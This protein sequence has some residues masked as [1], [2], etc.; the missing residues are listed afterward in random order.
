[1]RRVLL[2]VALAG[3]GRVGFSPRP[4][5]SV[6]DGPDGTNDGAG[7]DGAPLAANRVFVT[8]T[9]QTAALGGLAGADAICQGLAN[10]AS[11]SGTYIALLSTTTVDA[12]TRLGSARGWV[13]SDGLPFADTAA[14]LF[15]GHVYFPIRVDELGRDIGTT[16]GLPTYSYTATTVT[17]TYAAGGDCAAFTGTSSATTGGITFAG[18]SGWVSTVMMLCSLQ[19]HL[20][21]FEIDRST[22]VPPPAISGRIAFL[23]TAW[24][25]G[26]GLASADQRCVTDAQAAGLPGTYH[27]LLATS[28]A[29]A[30]SRFNT[31]GPRWVRPDGIAVFD[32]ASTLATGGAPLTAIDVTAAGGYVPQLYVL[33]GATTSNVVGSATTT[34]NDWT[35]TATN[36]F[37]DVGIGYE[38]GPAGF[39]YT[40]D[41]CSD[42]TAR[43]YCLQD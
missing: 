27:A 2:V 32:P 9:T 11:L 22:P 8:S 34:C 25:S 24:A 13:R 37:P 41:R 12:K 30:A 1:M 18:T 29:S 36:Q 42:A 21:C 28:T 26:G 33:T 43:V 15:A 19:L 3:C 5:N 35:S 16:E 23:S 17:G 38:S 4:S 20:L 6:P 40:T 39:S 31:A 10:H 14:D 7:A